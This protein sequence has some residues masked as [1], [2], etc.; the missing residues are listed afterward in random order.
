MSDL[1]R[2]VR[3]LEQEVERLR[4]LLDEHDLRLRELLAVLAALRS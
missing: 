3:W 2:R 1:E 4:R